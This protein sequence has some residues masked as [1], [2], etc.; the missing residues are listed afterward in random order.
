MLNKG[1]HNIR[2]WKKRDWRQ[3]DLQ[4]SDAEGGSAQKIIFPG[5]IVNYNGIEVPVNFLENNPRCRV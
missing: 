1:K 3:S 5:M 4:A 2:L